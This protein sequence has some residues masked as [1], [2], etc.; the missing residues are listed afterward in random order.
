MTN[1]KFRQVGHTSQRGLIERNGTVSEAEQLVVKAM[2]KDPAKCS[3][4]TDYT[5]KDCI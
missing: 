4:G 2:D 5:S 3:G 1:P